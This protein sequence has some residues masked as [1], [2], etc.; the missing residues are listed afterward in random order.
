PVLS[1]ANHA[2]DP[3]NECFSAGPAEEW[4]GALSR[5]EGLHVASRTSAFAFKG[6]NE[7]VRR[8]GER[9]NVRTV[10]EGR[11]RKAGSRLRIS[12]QLV[13]TADG[14]Q[15]WSQVFNRQLEDVF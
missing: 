15:L 8:T 10:L 9:L 7:D 4:I 14:Y 6:K 12:A 3:A 13:S 5:I 2:P 11:V 1:A